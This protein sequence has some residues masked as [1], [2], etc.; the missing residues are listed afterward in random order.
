MYV[1]FLQFYRSYTEDCLLLKPDQSYTPQLISF[2]IWNQFKN[3]FYKLFR[4]YKILIFYIAIDIKVFRSYVHMKN[5][6][7]YCK[8]LFSNDPGIYNKNI[9]Y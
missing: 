5:N 3:C 1:I 9:P 6:N 8:I 2:K 4:L 7:N